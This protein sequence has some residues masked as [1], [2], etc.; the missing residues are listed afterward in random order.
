M[1]DNLCKKIYM[2]MYV[3]LSSLFGKTKFSF[4]SG[5]TKELHRKPL[6]NS[7]NCFCQ[8]VLLQVVYYWLQDLSSVT[9]CDWSV[10]IGQ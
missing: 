7:L 6:R 4:V 8:S 10:L 2:Y 9:S 3:L 1:T 5:S